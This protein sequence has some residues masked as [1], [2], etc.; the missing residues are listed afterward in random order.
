[1]SGR[2]TWAKM[3]EKTFSNFSGQIQYVHKLNENESLYASA[4]Q[5]FRM[6]YLREMYTNAKKLT[7]NTELRPEKG[8]HYEVGWKKNV[9]NHSWKVALFGYDIKD[10]ITYTLGRS[11]GTSY[12]TNQDAKNFGLETSVKYTNR[13]GFGYQLGF[14]F[15]NPKVKTSSD[16]APST[17]T[18]KDYWDRQYARNQVTG[19]VNYTKGK[20]DAN[21]LGTYMFNRVASPTS[22]ESF[23]IKPYFLTSIHIKYALDA[24]QDITFTMENLLGRTDNF[25]GST[26][27]YYSTPRCFLIKYSY[28]F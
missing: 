4:G 25:G 15:A 23:S 19:G 26:T 11:G 16:N 6:P 17:V 22:S 14:T 12:S 18:V 10:N 21:L 8:I 3:P 5:S 9:N 1:M 7:G 13:D 28:N 27:A 2:Q 20:W 24:H